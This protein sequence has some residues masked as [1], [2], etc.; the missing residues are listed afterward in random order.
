M[1]GPI[2]ILST[3]IVFKYAKIGSGIAEDPPNPIIKKNS[4]KMSD[5]SVF[6]CFFNQFLGT[7][8]SKNP[9]F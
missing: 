3:P 4:E 1:E 6:S 9:S 7:F 2:Q 8:W 5:F